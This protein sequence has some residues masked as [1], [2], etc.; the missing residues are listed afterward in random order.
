MRYGSRNLLQ[1]ALD[2]Y[3]EE[4]NEN[5]LE[6]VILFFVLLRFFISYA[7]CFIDVVGVFFFKFYKCDPS[8]LPPE[9]ASCLV[10]L[11][12]DRETE[13]FLCDSKKQA[14]NVCLQLFYTL[15]HVLLGLF[16]SPTAINGYKN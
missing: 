3:R 10:Q 14:S 6:K 8:N 4:G 1:A 5:S 13:V 7:K 16:L 2:Q 12:P 11:Q 15:I 9:L